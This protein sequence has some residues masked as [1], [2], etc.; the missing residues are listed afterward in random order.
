[1]SA[2][3]QLWRMDL[4]VNSSQPLSTGPD[5]L[6]PLCSPDSKWAYYYDEQQGSIMKAPMDGSPPS[7]VLST[8]FTEFDFLPQWQ[9]V[10]IQLTG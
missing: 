5:I 1:M 8:N 6:Y 3:L 10:G 4:T 2:R 7:K 9:N